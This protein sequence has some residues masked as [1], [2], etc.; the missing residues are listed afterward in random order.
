[1]INVGCIECF[2]GCFWM[3]KWRNNNLFYLIEHYLKWR[4]IVSVLQIRETN[5]MEQSFSWEA[6]RSL[7]GQ[8]ISHILWNQ[9]VHHVFHKG[10]V[11]APFVSQINPVKHDPLSTSWKSILILFSYPFLGLVS[12]LFPSGFPTKTLYAPLLFPYMPQTPPMLFFL[13]WS[14]VLYLVKGTD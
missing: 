11:P 6:D 14:F 10:P 13:I 9:K 7:A 5:C 4:G 1:M 8:E 3:L 2:T 12:C